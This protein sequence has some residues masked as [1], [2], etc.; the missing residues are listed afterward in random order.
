MNVLFLRPQPAI[1]SLKYALAFRSVHADIC[2][3]HCYT[4]KTLT[5]L[6]GYG[7]IYFEK[8]IKLDLKNLEKD[9]KDI[10]DRYHIDL[11]HSQNAPDFLTVSAIRAVE[12]MPIIHENQD[13]ISLQETPYSP[14]ANVEKQLVDERIANECCDARINVTNELSMYIQKKYGLKKD[15]VFYNYTS[16]SMI[17]TSFKDKL[18]KKDGEVHIVYEGT[19]ASIEGDHYDLREI[20]N[21][22]AS[23]GMN[24]HIYDS[25]SN[26]EYKKLDDSDELI[27]YHGHLDPRR[28]LEEMT[29]Y[30]FGWA[31]FNVTKNKAH[32]DVA[33][34][35]KAFE[36]ISC[37]L[38]VLSFHHEAQK[39]FIE[40]HEVGL[41][42][43]DLKEMK[44]KLADKE[45]LANLQKMALEKRY[46]F[47][48]ER[49]IHK[50]TDL[51]DH[52]CNR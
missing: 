17:P 9:L 16:E 15:V 2:I 18:S 25:H 10:V 13:S 30:D 38:P 41:V 23:L 35:N 33:L 4:R 48:V 21:D 49:N 43:K 37:G 5:E 52:I 29:Q 22:I 6:Y 47:T 26:K 40:K 12:N 44:E 11:I 36:Y 1:R 32:I 8:L 28:L 19:L 46:Q 7:D 50:I 27:H 42:F 20:F 24:I 14:D 31:G 3:Y 51:Y 39:K 34:P 45:L